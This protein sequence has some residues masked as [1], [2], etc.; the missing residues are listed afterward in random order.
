M[1]TTLDAATSRFDKSRTEQNPIGQ[2]RKPGAYAFLFAATVCAFCS[3]LCDGLAAYRQ[4][5]D[6][7]SRGIQR[8]D[9]L[10]H[11]LLQ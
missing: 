5:E 6:L 2:S 4:Y 11:A 1:L 3:A 8:D 9:A 10:G 7:R